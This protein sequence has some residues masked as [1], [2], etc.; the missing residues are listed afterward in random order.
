MRKLSHTLGIAAGA[1]L[2]LSTLF[3]CNMGRYAN[4]QRLGIDTAHVKA[5][6][7]PNY[8][9][10]IGSQT[11]I[12]VPLS[13]HWDPVHHFLCI[14]KETQNG[15]AIILSLHGMCTDRETGNIRLGGNRDALY[16]YF[17]DRHSSQP[18]LFRRDETLTEIDWGTQH[19]VLMQAIMLVDLSHHLNQQNL[20]YDKI[21]PFSNG[22][23]SNSVLC[24]FLQALGH[25]LP[26]RHRAFWDPGAERQ[27]IPEDWA[28]YYADWT[29]PD[30]SIEFLEWYLNQLILT[31]EVERGFVN[32]EHNAPRYQAPTHRR[33]RFIDP[34]NPFEPYEPLII[35]N[36]KAQ[37]AALQKDLGD[38]IAPPPP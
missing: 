11:I 37:W 1:G 22:Q 13:N 34:Y 32:S 30:E 7:N 35:E 2:S 3:G 27:L 9:I 5:T 4:I 36:A 20:V 10:W 29:P 25:D 33:P 6:Q 38:L 8:S 12:D 31:A 16:V 15:P 14:T 24:A 28:S 18:L 19:D 21:E 23:N 26:T 17:Y